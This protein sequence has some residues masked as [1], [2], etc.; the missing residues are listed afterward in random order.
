M[1]MDIF[2]SFDI[3]E[4]NGLNKIS[5]NMLMILSL[6]FMMFLYNK[7]WVKKNKI[8]ISTLSLKSIIYKQIY[9]TSMPK[10]SG[11]TSILTTIFIM[12]ILINTLGLTPMSFSISSH[13]IFTMTLSLPLWLS[14]VYS[15][16]IKNKKQFIAK[17]LPD[18]APMWLNP[19][20][21]LIETISIMV[22]PITLSVRLAANMS[23]GH[24]VLGLVGIYASSAINTS[25]LSSITLMTLTV[26]Y[27]MF[28][29][30]ICSI[31]A[32]I[33]CLL[34]TLYSEDHTN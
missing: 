2:S 32:Y 1:L 11:L 20:L 21:V 6:L 10:I 3:F 13:L 14:I 5:P 17:L 31:Q 25:L 29:L 12:L 28:E 16:L 30:A 18:G 34:L 9:N 4:F 33:F 23:A 8:H 22:R 27:I 7:L 24:I 15:S 26:G 19:F